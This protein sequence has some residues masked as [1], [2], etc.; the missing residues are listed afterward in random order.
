MIG[1]SFAADPDWLNRATRKVARY[2]RCE[3][4]RYGRERRVSV[5]P[6]APLSDGI[7]AAGSGAHD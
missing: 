2:W 1:Q 6:R 7:G 4:E 3:R 5:P